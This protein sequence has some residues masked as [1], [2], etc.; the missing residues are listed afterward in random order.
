MNS[1]NRPIIDY[2]YKTLPN[3]FDEYES[4]MIYNLNIYLNEELALEL[5]GEMG[6]LRNAVW[7]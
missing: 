1:L 4:N 3:I 2:L 7:I 5:D 6:E